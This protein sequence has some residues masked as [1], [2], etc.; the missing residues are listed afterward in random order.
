MNGM[1]RSARPKA[2]TSW[3]TGKD[4]AKPIGALPGEVVERDGSVF[5]D[6]LPTDSRG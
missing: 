6:L 2:V 1:I 4:S 5:A 3:S